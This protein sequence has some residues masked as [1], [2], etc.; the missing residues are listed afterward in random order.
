M[1]SPPTQ[2]GDRVISDQTGNSPNSLFPEYTPENIVNK[3]SNISER[4]KKITE[5]AIAYYGKYAFPNQ[6]EQD[7]TENFFEANDF[8]LLQFTLK[9]ALRE[10]ILL[11]KWKNIP[12]EFI[13]IQQE[14][15][16]NL[17]DFYIIKVFFSNKP[18]KY[19]DI[20]PELLT[21]ANNRV[22]SL[23]TSGKLLSLNFKYKVWEKMEET[24]KRKLADLIYTSFRTD[25]IDP[26]YQNLAKSLL[27]VLNIQSMNES[28]RTTFVSDL[29]QAASMYRDKTALQTTVRTWI[30]EEGKVIHQRK[31]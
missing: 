19:N 20:D 10:N 2:E 30:R 7:L 9:N 17:L 11:L 15:V 3:T 6:S 8:N 26:T 18:P 28:D 1:I 22:K 25:K 4:R 5:F 27:T 14:Y 29:V 24:E 16:N 23:L 13:Q 31:K 12:N 21:I